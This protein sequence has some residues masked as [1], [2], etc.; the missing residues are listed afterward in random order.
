V[1]GAYAY[2]ELLDKTGRKAIV[3]V[4]GKPH[5]EAQ[6][7]LDHFFIKLLDDEHLLKNAKEIILV[8]VSDP[9]WVSKNIDPKNVVEV[10]DHRQVHAVEKFSNAKSQVELVGAA[11]TLVAERLT[12]AKYDISKKAA[13]ML[14]LAIV[15]NTINFKAKVTTDRDRKAARILKLK[16]EVTDKFVHEM[17]E[18]KSAFREPLKDVFQADN[19]I[20]YLG[21]VAQSMIQ[22]EILEAEKFV[23]ENLA[24]IKDVLSEIKAKDRLDYIYLT[25]IDLE[26]GENFFVVADKESEKVFYEIMGVKFANGI[27]RHPIMMRKEI[28]ALFREHFEA[29]K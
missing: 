18:H 24:E 21:P 23:N 28:I 19:A 13:A 6:F 7:V 4:S 3:V 5:P 29:K 1:A 17:F 2:A 14:Y 11:A 10:I 9:D 20:I 22:L 25:C 12:K 8:D 15:S 27:A 26:K 16:G